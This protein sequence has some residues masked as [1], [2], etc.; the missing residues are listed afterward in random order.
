[1]FQN[2]SQVNSG[3][4]Q[5]FG[6]TGLGLAVSR[7]LCR[8]MGGDITVESEFGNGA[9]FTIRLPTRPPTVATAATEPGETEA[10]SMTGNRPAVPVID[11]ELAAPCSDD[12]PGSVL[13]VGANGALSVEVV[14]L[15]RR[16]NLAVIAV[17]S[18]DD[19]LAQARIARPHA[20]LLGKIDTPNNNFDFLKAFANAVDPKPMPRLVSIRTN[21]SDAWIGGVDK[22]LDASGNDPQQIAHDLLAIISGNG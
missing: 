21:K 18:V 1:M 5:E 2:F 6:G 13:V 4:A 11:N 8:L 9:C 14:E 16:E 3:I 12:Q 17:A 20:V 19:A 15:L 7:K 10:A 22:T